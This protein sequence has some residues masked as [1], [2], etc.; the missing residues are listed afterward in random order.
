M[1]FLETYTKEVCAR[2]SEV[3]AETDN[4]REAAKILLETEKHG[5]KIFVFGTGHSYMTGQDIYCR[6]GGYAKVH[7]ICE[8]ELTTL[9]HPTKS[10]RLERTADYADTLDEIYEIHNGDVLIVVSNSGRN[11]LVAEYALRAKNKGARIIAITSLEHSRTVSSRH[12]SGLRLFEIA[13]AVLDNHAPYGD[14]TTQIGTDTKMGPVSTI[15]SSFIAHCLM[16][17]LVELMKQEGM[18]APVF[19]SANMDGADEYNKELFDLYVFNK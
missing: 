16:G 13:D 11:S 15:T 2:I 10:T 18:V 5:G 3:A 9:T 8:I 17:C 7:P 6:A 19:K 4:I 12:P 1:N 14:A